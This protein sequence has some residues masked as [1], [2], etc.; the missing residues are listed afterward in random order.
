MI[1]TSKPKPPWTDEEPHTNAKN[2]HVCATRFFC[3][4][5]ICAH[6]FELCQRITPNGQMKSR[7]GT[8]KARTSALPARYSA[9]LGR[10]Y[11]QWEP[12]LLGTG[13]QHGIHF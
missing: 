7:R 10:F 1:L 2:A 9:P 5:P 8:Q 4:L 6:G 12:V 11:Q 13:E 3:R